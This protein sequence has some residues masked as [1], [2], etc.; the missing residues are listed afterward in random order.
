MDA[1]EEPLP[2]V[3]AEPEDTPAVANSGV[4][5]L[6]AAAEMAEE[7]AGL[8]KHQLE[9]PLRLQQTLKV[10][11]P[12]TKLWVAAGWKSLKLTADL[13]PQGLKRPE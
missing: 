5:P 3:A 2:Q 8:K 6:E 11:R 1:V 10:K 4:A 9:A 13:H 7:A 12:H